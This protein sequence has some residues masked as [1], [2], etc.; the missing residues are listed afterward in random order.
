MTPSSRHPTTLLLISFLGFIAIALPQGI[1][2]V[3]WLQIQGTFNQPLEALGLL[4]GAATLGRLVVS[5]LSGRLISLT[6]TGTFCL[7]GGMIALAGTLGYALAPSWLTLLIASSFLGIGTGIIESSFNTYVAKYYS[8]S[9]MNWLHAAFGLGTTLGPFLVTVMVLD[10]GAS[11]RWS[12][13]FTALLFALLSLALIITR[14]GWQSLREP[15]DP[16][17]T[18]GQASLRESLKHV[19]VWLG[20]ILF[21]TYGGVATSTGQLSNSLLVEGRGVDPRLAG[22]WIG[23]YWGSFTG[24]RILLGFLAER[25]GTVRLLRLGTLLTA[26]GALLVWWHPFPGGH[27]AGL[28]LMGVS[29]AP[30]FP[31]S[32]SRTPGFVGPRHSANTIGFQIAAAGLGATLLPGL[33]GALAERYGLEVLGPC[34]L[35]MALLQF[36]AQESVTWRENAPSPLTPHPSPQEP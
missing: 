24:G 21:F 32:T 6:G 22:S 16:Q 3:A 12:Y 34:F 23:I 33:A 36:L 10:Q 25:I 31:S 35:L 14:S 19:P 29:L 1:L 17:G 8:V 5:F 4:L 20:V 11:W 2:G 7:T 26:V 30:V 28:A 9:Q 27:F 18:L 13:G 15:Q